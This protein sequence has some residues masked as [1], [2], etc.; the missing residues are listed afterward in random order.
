MANLW[1]LCMKN[2]KKEELVYDYRP[3]MT[4]LLLIYGTFLIIVLICVHSRIYM[5]CPYLLTSI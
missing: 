4:L 2:D 5:Y 3:V 1:H